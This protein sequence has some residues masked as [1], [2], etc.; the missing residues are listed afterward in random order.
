[1]IVEMIKDKQEKNFQYQLSRSFQQQHYLKGTTKNHWILQH[2]AVKQN[3]G[4][5]LQLEVEKIMKLGEK[6][7][8]VSNIFSA[9]RA[10]E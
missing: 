5:K 2:N 7:D 3:Q 9:Q 8:V 1:M 4:F 6:N 10:L